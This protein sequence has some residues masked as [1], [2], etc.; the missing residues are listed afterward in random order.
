MR[1]NVSQE[2]GPGPASLYSFTPSS[3]LVVPVT[4]TLVPKGIQLWR[5]G[6][7]KLPSSFSVF[8][9]TGLNSVMNRTKVH[10][11]VSLHTYS[12]QPT[13]PNSHTCSPL[14]I[15]SMTPYRA[16]VCWWEQTFQVWS[17]FLHRSMNPVDVLLER[18]ICRVF[19]A[20]GGSLKRCRDC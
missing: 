10:L 8:G 6:S 20:S 9:S 18:R 14:V 3:F 4:G 2:D 19:S 13:G 7:S 11:Q 1:K 17:S 15:F 16:V 5:F 12:D